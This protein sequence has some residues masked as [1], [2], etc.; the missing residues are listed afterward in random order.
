M[1][2]FSCVLLPR[3]EFLFG[4]ISNF[5]S[6]PVRIIERTNHQP[7]IFRG[8]TQTCVFLLRLLRSFLRGS[9]IA[10]S[11][12]K[13]GQDQFEFQRRRETLD[14]VAEAKECLGSYFGLSDLTYVWPKPSKG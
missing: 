5:E 10:T 2:R 11:A 4:R 13:V 7:G 8:K 1:T 14:P 9:R 3:I 6:I 12:I